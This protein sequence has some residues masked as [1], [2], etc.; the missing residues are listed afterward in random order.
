MGVV[1]WAG[2]MTHLPQVLNEHPLGNGDI[3]VLEV[4]VG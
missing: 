1:K 4:G 3:I 2:S